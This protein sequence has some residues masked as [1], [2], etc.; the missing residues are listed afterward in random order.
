MACP[1]GS[2]ISTE[3]HVCPVDLCVQAPHILLGL[4]EQRVQLLQQIAVTRLRHLGEL[5]LQL[6]LYLNR[7]GG[8][9]LSRAGVLERGFSKSI[10][11]GGFC[12]CKNSIFYEKKKW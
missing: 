6:G 1:T 9:D 8:F 12:V 10:K 7:Q 3:S 2:C 4:F 5:G 11:Q